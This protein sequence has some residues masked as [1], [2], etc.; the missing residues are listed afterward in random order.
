MV[1]GAD[2]L[3]IIDR[4]KTEMAK[5]DLEFAIIIE[6]ITDAP[7]QY[8]DAVQGLVKGAKQSRYTPVVEDLRYK[9]FPSFSN[10][11]SQS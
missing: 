7:G 1:Y 11:S 6:G 4:V 2:M 3:A 10:I 5:E 8:V 9:T